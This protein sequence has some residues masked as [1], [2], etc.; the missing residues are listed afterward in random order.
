MANQMLECR[1]IYPTDLSSPHLLPPGAVNFVEGRSKGNF[2]FYSYLHD[3]INPLLKAGKI[4]QRDLK[5]RFDTLALAD[6]IIEVAVGVTT[7]YEY[8][9]D[10][11]IFYGNPENSKLTPEMVKAA[12]EFILKAPEKERASSLSKPLGVT[13]M[14]ITLEGRISGM[15]RAKGE[16]AGQVIHNPAGYMKFKKRAAELNPVD[17]LLSELADEALVLEKNIDKIMFAG[18]AAEPKTLETDLVYFVYT[19]LQDEHFADNGNWRQAKDA[20]DHSRAFTFTK[21]QVAEMMKTG[22]AP[23]G[24]AYKILCPTWLGYNVFLNLK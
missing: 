5:V 13:G 22:K 15:V 8:K 19:S 16:Y 7:F 11:D 3:N 12:R 1:V 4:E 24:N 2:S 18:I 17:D 10:Y 14:V 6:S 23:D 21:P 9:Q 20:K